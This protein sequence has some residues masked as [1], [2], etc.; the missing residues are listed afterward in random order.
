M[1]CTLNLNKRDFFLNKNKSERDLINN[2]K[3]NSKVN[4]IKD[5]RHNYRAYSFARKT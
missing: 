4:T 1:I 3:S 5:K 2:F